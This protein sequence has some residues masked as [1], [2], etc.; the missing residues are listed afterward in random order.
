MMKQKLIAAGVFQHKYKTSNPVIIILHV[1]R[2][3]CSSCRTLLLSRDALVQ[4][5]ARTLG[6]SFV[7]SLPQLRSMS[8][9]CTY[10]QQA[11]RSRARHSW[12][13]CGSSRD[14]ISA[15]GLAILIEIFFGFPTFFQ[16][17]A[18]TLPQIKP[19]KIFSAFFLIIPALPY[20]STLCRLVFRNKPE[21]ALGVPGR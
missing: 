21:V 4:I 19:R 13:V 15:R 14:Q 20:Y 17:G 10:I 7:L 1:I 18:G 12:F 3:I 11:W 5:S 2:N 9:G 8:L 16:T 6:L